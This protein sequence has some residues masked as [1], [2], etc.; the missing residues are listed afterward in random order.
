MYDNGQQDFGVFDPLHRVISVR[1]PRKA[2]RR[3]PQTFAS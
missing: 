2:S 1:R 3:L